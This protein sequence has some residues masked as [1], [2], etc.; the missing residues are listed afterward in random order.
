MPD[1]RSKDKRKLN[2]WLNLELYKKL[3]LLS[4][5]TGKNMSEL[6]TEWICL[7]TMNVELTPEDYEQIAAYMRRKR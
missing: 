2:V 6:V 3:E 5:K 1:Q 7:G 4:Q